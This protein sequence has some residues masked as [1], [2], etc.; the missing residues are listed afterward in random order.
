[1]QRCNSLRGRSESGV[2]ALGRA[3]VQVRTETGKVGADGMAGGL[4]TPLFNSLREPTKTPCSDSPHNPVCDCLFRGSPG[5]ESPQPSRRIHRSRSGR[6]LTSRLGVNS[7]VE[8]AAGCRHKLHKMSKEQ[9]R[10]SSRDEVGF[11]S[12]RERTWF[13]RVSHD[14]V[15]ITDDCSPETVLLRKEADRT[16]ATA[17]MRSRL[18]GSGL[19]QEQETRVCSTTAKQTTRRKA[20]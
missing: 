11:R 13:W 7:V 4:T 16:T 14:E 9:P 20:R 6:R 17:K 18:V 1:M 12:P 2:S 19:W 10:L 3:E 5:P 8:D 15:S